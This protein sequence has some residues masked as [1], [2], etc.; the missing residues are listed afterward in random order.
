MSASMV[1]FLAAMSASFFA[2]SAMIWSSPSR[3]CAVSTCCCSR[4]RAE[5]SADL[6]AVL[7][8]TTGLPFYNTSQLSFQSVASDPM[9]V[10]S[11]LRSHIAGYSELIVDV[12]RAYDFDRQISRLDGARL[13]YPV[14]SR[15]A[16]VD[17]GPQAVSDRRMGAVFE[18]LVQTFA[19][20][21]YDAAGE[22]FTP[23]D[24]VRVMAELLVP[25]DKGA[26]RRTVYDPACGMGGALLETRRQIEVCNPSAVVETFGQE[27]KSVVQET[28]VD[29]IQL[30]GLMK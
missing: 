19:A 3:Y 15:F 23:R 4:I 16:D 14:V 25:Q 28:A 13:L 29:G 1:F 21:N 5:D 27:I 11:N 2:W 26:G 7:R 17:L 20:A 9:Y 8:E 30:G 10:A 12:L 18:E 6:D 24:V 22:Y